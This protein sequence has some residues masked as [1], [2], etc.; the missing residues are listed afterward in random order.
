MG[1]WFCILFFISLALGLEIKAQQPAK[2]APPSAPNT[3]PNKT[4]KVKLLKRQELVIGG[5][6]RNYKY[7]EPGFV[8]HEGFMYGGYADYLYRFVPSTSVSVGGNLIYGALNYDGGLCDNFGNCEPYQATTND[9]IMRGHGRVHINPNS[10]ISLQ[11]G[12]GFRYL[13][14]KGQGQG[15]Y[16]RTGTWFYVPVAAGFKVPLA[17][18]AKL[19]FLAE[20]DMIVSGGI[21][22]N[23]SE[24]DTTY[25]DVYMTQTGGGLIIKTGYEENQFEVNLFYESWSL[26]ESSPV[27]TGGSTFIEPKNQSQSFGLQLGMDFL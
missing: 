21:K 16:Q 15:F 23:L 6:L 10:N 12:L 2:P 8:T 13:S 27:T 7:S 5:E 4:K 17:N 18:Q 14:D 24:V 25:S 26:N 11:L 19:N 1:N 22:S 3:Y 20:Y 9:L